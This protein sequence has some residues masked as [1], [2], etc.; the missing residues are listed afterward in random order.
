[1]A[2]IDDKEIVVSYIVQWRDLRRGQFEVVV[3]PISMLVLPSCTSPEVV[4]LLETVIWK[5][6]VGAK[7]KSIDG[8][9]EVLVTIAYRNA[10]KGEC[11]THTEGGDIVV[12]YFVR[13]QDKE[14]THFE[15]GTIPSPD[16]PE[17]AAEPSCSCS[18]RSFAEHPRRPRPRRLVAT[19]RSVTIARKTAGPVN[20]WCVSMARTSSSS[21]SSNG[22]IAKRVSSRY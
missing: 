9:R 18:R 14:K 2:H 3:P 1:M 22:V 19:A 10:R 5:S 12:K 20:A 21:T 15:V 4:R 11:V 17:C 8:H 16:L 7:V 6:P 13:W